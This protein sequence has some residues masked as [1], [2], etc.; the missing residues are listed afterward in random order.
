MFRRLV[1][2]KGEMNLIGQFFL[3]GSPGSTVSGYN[4]MTDLSEHRCT[5]FNLVR[6]YK[7]IEYW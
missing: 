4:Q 5:A 7:K 1:R 2:W 6:K 3:V